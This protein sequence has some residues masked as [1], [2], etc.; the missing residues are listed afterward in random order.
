LGGFETLI[1]SAASPLT[2]CCSAEAAPVLA[3]EVPPVAGNPGVS[4]VVDPDTEEELAA[5]EPDPVLLLDFWRARLACPVVL[6][7]VFFV[8]VLVA[9]QRRPL[10]V[11][12]VVAWL[13]LRLRLTHL[14]EDPGVLALARRLEVV[15][16]FVVVVVV[17]VVVGAAVVPVVA[18]DG[19]ELVVVV[20]D[21][22]VV[23]VVV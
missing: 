18:D 14:R 17:V 5:V 9:V 19:V 6:G 7:V 2:A 16:G 8:L 12:S 4:A 15:V 3:L 11:A 1:A 10:W 13:D 20:G 23:V 22:L 21:A